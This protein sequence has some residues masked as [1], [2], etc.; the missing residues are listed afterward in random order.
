M[1]ASA[2]VPLPPF[3]FRL[4][5]E[6]V[7]WR[8]I[9]A[10][11]VDRVASELDFQ[12]L[13]EHIAGVT[14]CSIE[15]ERCQRCQAPVDSAVLK[16]F[17]LSQ[18]TVEY[19]LHSQDYLSLSL[20]AAEERVQAEQR[21]KE[22]IHLMFQKHADELKTLKDELKQR[23]KIITSQQAMI[24]TGIAGYNKVCMCA[25]VVECHKACVL[26]L[27]N[28]GT[29]FNNRDAIGILSSYLHHSNQSIVSCC[30]MNEA[31]PVAD[32][33]SSVLEVEPSP[34]PQSVPN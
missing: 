20:Q 16:L 23:K 29:L 12:T 28:A 34:C 14:F 3:R 19:L 15:A 10:L 25:C 24:S 6:S 26:D 13:Q 27:S 32:L 11:D 4:Q 9:G 17:R 31:D 1:Q 2:A 5:R 33:Y 30:Q 18:L 22:Q 7:D 21:E 8:R